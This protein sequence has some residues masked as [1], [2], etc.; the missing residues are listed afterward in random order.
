MTALMP[1]GSHPRWEPVLLAA[2]MLVAAFAARPIHLAD[3]RVA[4][5]GAPLGSAAGPSH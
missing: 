4:A 5:E 3:R 1:P 2:P